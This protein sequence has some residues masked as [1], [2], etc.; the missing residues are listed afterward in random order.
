MQELGDLIA[1]AEKRAATETERQR[2][3]LWRNSI[4]KWALEG[5][6]DYE[7]HTAKS[8]ARP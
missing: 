5:R 8:E 7:A 2:V 3:A 4:W 6:A 1:Q